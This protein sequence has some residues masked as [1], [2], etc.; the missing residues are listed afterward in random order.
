LGLDVLQHF[1]I[2][3]GSES[4][5][6]IPAL[7]GFKTFAGRS[8]TSFSTLVVSNSDISES[9]RV[10]NSHLVQ[11][12]GDETEGL[13]R[14][15]NN[16]VV[17]EGYNSSND[18]GRA[19]SSTNSFD[20]SLRKDEDVGT[21]SSQIRES[22]SSSVKVRGRRKGNTGVQILRYG[23][24]LEVR[25]R[26]DIRET[27]SRSEVGLSVA[28]TLFNTTRCARKS[29]ATRR[30]VREVSFTSGRRDLSSSNRGNVRRASREDRVQVVLGAIR[31][32]SSVSTGVT[33]GGDHGNS[34]KTKLLEFSVDTLNING[35]G[36]T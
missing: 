14:L 22:S 13:A 16:V 7:G 32:S 19:R 2:D 33:R 9:S 20:L 23:S 35:V 12:R 30:R 31:I 26:G 34:T 3:R 25:G 1:R 27:T 36:N 24:L 28:D 21:E 11:E 6:G 10:C 15:G 8:A 29:G 5:N 17:E 18:R 4:R